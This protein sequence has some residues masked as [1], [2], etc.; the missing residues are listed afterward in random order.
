MSTDTRIKTPRTWRRVRHGVD[1]SGE[2]YTYEERDIE[3]FDVV[4]LVVPAND[5]Y[6]NGTKYQKGI[7][8]AVTKQD[9]GDELLIE[10]ENGHQVACTGHDFP[11]INPELGH[12]VV[13][14]IE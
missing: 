13:W 3:V 5:P 12:R 9:E 8:V 1:Y 4:L 10:L 11:Y 6:N 7:V 14:P 2:P